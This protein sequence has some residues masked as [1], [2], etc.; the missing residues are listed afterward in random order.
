M[1]RLHGANTGQ[2]DRDASRMLQLP[3]ERWQDIEW[4]GVVSLCGLWASAGLD[5]E[6]R[7]LQVPQGG[8]RVGIELFVT[9]QCEPQVQQASFKGRR[10]H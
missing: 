10:D 2:R 3:G 8:H 7:V 1:S 4:V 5:E 9:A 6:E